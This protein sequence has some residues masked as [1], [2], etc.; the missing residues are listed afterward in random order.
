[1][2][3]RS[4]SNQRN[5]RSFSQP[6]LEPYAVP[7]SL[8]APQE[9][10][11][12]LMPSKAVWLIRKAI[13]ILS[14]YQWMMLSSRDKPSYPWLIGDQGTTHPIPSTCHRITSGR[15]SSFSR[16]QSFQD[17]HGTN[18]LG[19]HSIQRALVQSSQVWCLS[20]RS[21]YQ[22]RSEQLHLLLS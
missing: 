20:F 14:N 19:T 6:S 21:K 1:M 3:V 4:S 11:Y 7:S 8:P 9:V 22:S 17:L 5:H 2:S 18:G 13:S 15:R 16:F 10:R 12:C